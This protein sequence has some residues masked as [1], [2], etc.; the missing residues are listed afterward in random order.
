MPSPAKPTAPA[1]AAQPN[2]FS[3]RARKEDMGRMASATVH[4]Y[5]NHT[6]CT[7]DKR[8]FPTRR[9][10]SPLEIVVDAHDGFIPLWAPDVTLHWRFAQSSLN[11]FEDP[12]AAATAIEAL[13]G[14]ALLA[15]GEAVPIRFAKRD[16]A[17]DF[18]IVMQHAADC[19]TN[20]CV[21][22]AAFFPDAGQHKFRLYPTM[23]EQSEQEQ[24]ETI[25]HELG[26]VFG[27][28]HFFAQIR[29]TAWR[30][31]IFGEHNPFSIMN[32]GSQSTLTAADRADL[33][34][35]YELARGGQL[36]KINGTPIRLVK[37]FHTLGQ[38]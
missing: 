21:L 3:P 24:F 4:V 12:A 32:Y 17:W 30:S 28:R 5:G 8:G 6:R 20:G 16:D 27:L 31:Q 34:R 10:L 22:A 26:H 7:T 25:C 33:K 2:P 19:D 18:E 36:T 11:F 35:L 15:W 1:R 38:A 14:R 9:N 37:P 23:F 29:E 13:L